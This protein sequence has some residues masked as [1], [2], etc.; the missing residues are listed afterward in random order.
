MGRSWTAPRPPSPPASH[1]WTPEPAMISRHAALVWRGP[2]AHQPRPCRPF[3]WFDTGAVQWLSWF[4][5]EPYQQ[6]PC[7]YEGNGQGSFFAP[8]ARG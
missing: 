1:F 2:A 6:Q 8:R 4:T 7:R 3:A 5:T